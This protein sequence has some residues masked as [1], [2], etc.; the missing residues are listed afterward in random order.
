[1]NYW[2]GDKIS[3]RAMEESDADFFYETLQD[4]DIQK[5]ESDI[6][7]PISHKACADFA[8]E[9]ASKGNNN[10]SPLLLRIKIRIGWEWLLR[11]W[12]IAGWEFLRV[13]FLLSQ[14]FKE[15]VMQ[16]KLYL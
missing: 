16:K 3:L 8:M 9:Q 4:M 14:N 7:V 12:K 6:R 2:Q 10:S 13:V 5:N 15:K 11:L 1:M